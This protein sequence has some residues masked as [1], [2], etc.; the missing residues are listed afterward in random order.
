MI[1]FVVF[2]DGCQVLSDFLEWWEECFICYCYFQNFKGCLFGVWQEYL[3][4]LQCSV[5]VEM[6]LCVV[7]DYV[8]DWVKCKV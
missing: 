2:V 7:D 1:N 5:G 6:V 4:Q 3:C 8:V